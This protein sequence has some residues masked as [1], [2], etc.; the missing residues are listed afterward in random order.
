MFKLTYD[1]QEKMIPQTNALKNTDN[2]YAK[3]VREIIG[4]LVSLENG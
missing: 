3:M 2:Q 1:V 4:L